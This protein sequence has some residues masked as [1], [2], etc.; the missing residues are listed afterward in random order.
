LPLTETIFAAASAYG[1][2]AVRSGI[3]FGLATRGPYANGY[4]ATF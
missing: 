4:A 3:D 2:S 1:M